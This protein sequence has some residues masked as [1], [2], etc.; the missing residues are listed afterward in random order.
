M[1]RALLVPEIYRI[2]LRFVDEGLDAEQTLAALART[3]HALQDPALDI[4]W[5]EIT[6]LDALF[7]CLTG[8]E[9]TASVPHN[10][11]EKPGEKTK[12]APWA[13]TA[14]GWA[15]VHKY[16]PRVR[17]LSQSPVSPSSPTLE[18]INQLPDYMRPLFPN[19][20]YLNW[21]YMEPRDF[22]YFPTLFPSSLE[23]LRYKLKAMSMQTSL[24][25]AMIPQS[26]PRIRD[27]SISSYAS[28]PETMGTFTRALCSWAHLERLTCDEITDDAWA[29]L[30]D[31]RALKHLSL[32]VQ[33]TTSFRSVRQQAQGQ[34]FR[35]LT[36]ITFLLVDLDQVTE[37]V[38]EM[39][40]A[41][42][43]FEIGC[44]HNICSSRAEELIHAISEYGTSSM[45]C[46]IIDHHTEKENFTSPPSLDYYA[47]RGNLLTMA[48]IRPLFKFSQL[49]KLHVDVVCKMNI[50]DQDVI[51]IAHAFPRLKELS[52]NSM[53]GCQGGS[54]VTFYGLFWL[55]YLC[56]HI[57]E[58]GVCLNAQDISTVDPS[59]G[60]PMEKCPP[61]PPPHLTL[62]WLFVGDSKISHPSKVA[63][64][65]YAIFPQLKTICSWTS[66]PALPEVTPEQTSEAK[67]FKR[68]WQKVDRLLRKRIRDRRR[69]E[70]RW[71]KVEQEMSSRFTENGFAWK[72]LPGGHVDDC[73]SSDADF[74]TEDGV[75]WSSEDSNSDSTDL[76]D[77]DDSD[78]DTASM[79]SGDNDG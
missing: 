22:S 67:E 13:L 56:P 10:T 38:K 34:P 53:Y 47:K 48:Q 12:E 52:L 11:L 64:V 5:E 43:H 29:H 27:L 75:S 74:G 68:R 4:L 20:K 1:H 42:A 41:P 78:E 55:L 32:T 37:F 58:L 31:L 23:V 69:F 70:E 72:G 62:T 14:D 25:I 17:R 21:S 15:I 65:L 40:V 30:A 9:T 19:L 35:N 45:D 6:S 26:F 44:H 79:G 66:H 8:G 77:S 54:T 59:S 50:G 60:I 71:E 28:I 3:C 18:E 63:D 51:D 46:I 49:T 7:Y 24:Q 61:T 33:P 16:A 39:R 57:H 36:W 73:P 2:I 76:D